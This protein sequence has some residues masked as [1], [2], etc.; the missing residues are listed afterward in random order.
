MTGG[1]VKSYNPGLGRASGHGI[2]TAHCSQ[3]SVR[4]FHPWAL[5]VRPHGHGTLEA[6]GWGPKR[7]S[8][9]CSPTFRPQDFRGNSCRHLYHWRE[10]GV[11]NLF[12]GRLERLTI[13]TTATASK[14]YGKLTYESPDQA[15]AAYLALVSTTRM[16]A[17]RPR[18]DGSLQMTVS[19]A[20]PLFGPR[21]AAPA[22]SVSSAHEWRPKL[23]SQ[24]SS[25]TFRPAGPR[26]AAALLP[27]RLRH[28]AQGRRRL[29]ALRRSE[30]THDP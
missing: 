19:K 22:A 2:R 24:A 9:T 16:A 13:V 30:G 5:W 7:G 11:R 12:R 8:Q 1:R 4:H 6:R 29:L 27:Q 15:C 25:P 17:G 23:G 20:L 14:E 3:L 10:G 18:P 21:G 28:L 26:G